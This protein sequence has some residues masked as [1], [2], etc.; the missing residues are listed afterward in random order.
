[1][2]REILTTDPSSV[3]GL[4]YRVLNIRVTELMKDYKLTY[5]DAKKVDNLDDGD[6]CITLS[7]G[8][9]AST[10]RSD[11]LDDEYYVDT[12]LSGHGVVKSQYVYEG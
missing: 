8:R 10:T 11:Y 3:G 12:H 6:G 5:Q 2:H 9:T 7:D 1:M 4:K